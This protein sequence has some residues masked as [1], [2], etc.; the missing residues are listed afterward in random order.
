MGPVAGFPKISL[1]SQRLGLNLREVPPATSARVFG[2]FQRASEIFPH[3]QR[4]SE[5]SRDVQ[6]FGSQAQKT[7][8]RLVMKHHLSECFGQQSPSIVGVSCTEW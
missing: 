6:R 8:G 4:F 2:G 1:S 5:V 7:S 3:Y